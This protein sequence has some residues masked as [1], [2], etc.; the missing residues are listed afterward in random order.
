MALATVELYWLRMLLQEL[1]VSLYSLLLV[2]WLDNIGDI[3]L[4]SNS[5][6][7]LEQSVEV[8]FHLS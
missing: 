1:H 7:I 4:T 5:A 2:L 3:A 8:D 6:F